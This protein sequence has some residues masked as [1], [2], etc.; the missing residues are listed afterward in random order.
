M[1]FQEG[2]LFFQNL[3]KNR[4]FIEN[5]NFV[6]NQKI[7]FLKF[8]K[9]SEFHTIIIGNPIGIRMIYG[10]FPKI[11]KISKFYF[12]ITYQIFVFQWNFDFFED[13]E[14]IEGPLE[15]AFFKVYP[16]SKLWSSYTMFMHGTRVT[17]KNLVKKSRVRQPDL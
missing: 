12:L 10:K 8:K 17:V 9:K 6:C 16:S 15:N 5:K 13:S 3:Q 7:K 14:R 11:F 4:K 2:L 1:R